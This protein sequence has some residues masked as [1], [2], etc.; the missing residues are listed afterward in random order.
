MI[1]VLLIET[2]LERCSTAWLCRQQNP[3]PRAQQNAAIT[4]EVHA[5]FDRHRGFY[6]A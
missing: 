6:G 1:S 5:V 3:G 2:L 4:T